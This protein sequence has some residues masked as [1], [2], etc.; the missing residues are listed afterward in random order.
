VSSNAARSPGRRCSPLRALAPRA[1]PTKA[2]MTMFAAWAPISS[3]TTPKPR[4]RAPNP[5]KTQP[6]SLG[7]EA[8]LLVLAVLNQTSTTAGIARVEGV[9]RDCPDRPQAI[10]RRMRR[11]S[12]PERVFGQSRAR[13]GLI[14]RRDRAAG[15]VLAHPSTNSRA[16]IPRSA[17]LAP[18]HQRHIGP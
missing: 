11:I 14:G 7:G 13:T 9:R 2:R 6:Q 18:R 4:P 12:L 8:Y 10:L 15:E 3:A 17:R 5:K 16:A 1:E